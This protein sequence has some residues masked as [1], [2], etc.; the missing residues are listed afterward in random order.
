MRESENFSEY[1][2][3]Q[4]LR[5]HLDRDAL[6]R[7]GEHFTTLLWHLK[8]Q[9]S[10]KA[11]VVE[12]YLMNSLYHPQYTKEAKIALR[13]LISY[14]GGP[15][16]AQEPPFHEIKVPQQFRLLKGGVEL[17]CGQRSMAYAHFM[18]DLEAKARKR[19]EPFVPPKELPY[20]KVVSYVRRYSSEK[21]VSTHIENGGE[22]FSRTLSAAAGGKKPIPEARKSTDDVSIKPVISHGS[23]VNRSST[24]LAPTSHNTSQTPGR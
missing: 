20:D 7:R 8:S 1:I 3:K 9:E 12:G 2:H 6:E 15:Q 23:R 21:L 5:A 14:L 13:R 11:P 24:N 22:D 17:D 16:S 18:L 4:R 19:G 10:G